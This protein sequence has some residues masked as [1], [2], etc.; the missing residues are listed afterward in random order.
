MS[1]GCVFGLFFRVNEIETE[2]EKKETGGKA[3]A[4]ARACF[5]SHTLSSAGGAGKRVGLL[6]KS[7]TRNVADMMIS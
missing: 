2:R 6:T 7:S 5:V 1:R 3:S 4:R